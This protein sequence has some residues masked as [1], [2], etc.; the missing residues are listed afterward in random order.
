[1]AFLQW[2]R[3]NFFEKQILKDESNPFSDLLRK[4]R[5]T[6]SSSGGSHIIVGD[7]NGWIHIIDRQLQFSS[8]VAYKVI[9]SHCHQV[10][11]SAYLFTVGGDEA[12]INPVVKIW[13]REKLNAEGVPYCS[14]V[15]RL[16]TG[17]IPSPVT[18]I[19]VL[20]TMMM[21]IAFADGHI[22]LFRGDITRDK[23]CKQKLIAISTSPVTGLAFKVNNTPGIKSM[24]KQIILFISTSKE[25]ISYNVTTR[26]KEIKTILDAFGCD[27]RCSCLKND[28]KQLEALFIVGRKDAI[29]FYQTDE[30]GPCVAF[31]GEK[32]MLYWYRNYLIVI[33]K[34]TPTSINNE[35]LN[36]VQNM[37]IITIYDISHK[38]I[39]YS[40]PIPPVSEVFG[41]WGSLYCIT[42]DGR[43]VYL[44]ESDT[45]TKLEMLFKKNQFSLAI[46]LAKS[47]QYDSD[48]LSDI[49]KHYGDHLYRKGDHDAAI[50]Q[51]IHTIGRL[52]AS[53]VIQKF[54]DAQ[55]IHNLT[56]YL[57]A[58][59][60]KGLANEDH[61]TLLINCYVKLKD[62]SKLDEFLK[63]DEYDANICHY[64]VE[65][66]IKVLRQAGYYD[67]ALYLAT[68]HK[69][70][71]SFLNISLEDKHD[72]NAA[73]DYMKHMDWPEVCDYM[74]KYG[75]ILMNEEPDKTTDILKR[76][77]TEYK[78]EEQSLDDQIVTG[79]DLLTMSER[80]RPNPEEF[81]HIFV[82]NSQKLIDFLEYMIE[83]R[84]NDCSAEVHNTLLELYLQSYKTEIKEDGLAIKE[85][86]ILK[87]LKNNEAK[88]EVEQAM[89]LCQM[90]HFD[91]G[92]LYLYEKAKMFKP[93]LNYYISNGNGANVLE[94]CQK[95]G[96]EDSN[97]WVDALWYFSK[98]EDN[99]KTIK[100]INEIETKRLLQPIMI[101]EILSRSESATLA[102]VKDY[103]VRWLTRENEQMAE[104]DK[105]IDQFKDDTERMRQQIDEMRSAPKVFQA[106]KCSACN[107]QLE[108]P[109]VHFLCDHSYHHHCFESY[110][111]ENDSDCPLCLPENRKILSQI[112]TLENVKNVN[113]MFEKQLQESDDC[114]TVI[115]NYF[116]QGIFNRLSPLT[117][118]SVLQSGA[119]GRPNT[120]NLVNYNTF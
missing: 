103:L 1:M 21:C 86:Q 65:T 54:L 27:V 37:Q 42:T 92:L 60:R 61:T 12:G 94:I 43:V 89:V 84:D 83:M 114:F 120:L 34:E 28:P 104:N 59:H 111:A 66:A 56:A 113:E 101:I 108:L 20:D 48:A 63:S 77:C 50:A 100:V 73:I 119:S 91:A 57:Q 105:L 79:L 64:D 25:I 18:A 85:S 102:V 97:L 44:R 75:R 90:S 5:I 78:P 13:N 87:L 45:Q 95:Y 15:I 10:I 96:N 72:A 38:F 67:N 31:E 36:E 6:C 76:L 14:R 69:R 29:Y 109:S 33:G 106:T 70:N 99:E 17:L 49:F 32:L 53:Y 71:D 81:I 110:A 98:T 22:L 47:Q 52:E 24:H 4:T 23:N 26:D 2:R 16:S 62:K 7:S 30:R 9:V 55:R 115:S 35:K 40:S 80:Q 41:E 51:Y 3:F 117:D 39:A 8:F 93:I 107:H 58:L 11:S 82:K 46:D 19:D 68:K 112:H 118:E 74:K 116:S 88:Y